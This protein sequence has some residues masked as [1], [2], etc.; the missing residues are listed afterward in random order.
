[1]RHVALFLA[2]DVCHP[3]F[4]SSGV[5]SMFN[6]FFCMLE[7]DGDDNVR[8]MS[9]IPSL[10]LTIETKKCK[11]MTETLAR[12]KCSMPRI[13]INKHTGSV[14]AISL[15][16]QPGWLGSNSHLHCTNNGVLGPKPSGNSMNFAMAVSTRETMPKY[17][18]DFCN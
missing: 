6:M 3:M 12:F 4:Q 14:A 17:R 13:I 9:D 1:M 8:V 10:K 15:V 18:N 5:N 16:S 11:D 7:I 2:M